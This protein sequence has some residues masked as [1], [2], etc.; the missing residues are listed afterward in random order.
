[1]IRAGID[2]WQAIN[3][4]ESF[5]SWKAIGAALAISKRHALKVTSANGA[6]GRNYSREF[7]TWMKQHGFGSMRASD[8]SHAIELHET[9][10]RLFSN[11]S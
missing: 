7:G 6:W 3:K 5:E 2:A 1:M 8:R 9:S 11:A 10:S 4:A